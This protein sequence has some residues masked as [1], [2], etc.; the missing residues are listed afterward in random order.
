MTEGCLAASPAKTSHNSGN[1]L[2][3]G[4]LFC[5]SKPFFDGPKQ[6][7]AGIGLGKIR[8]KVHGL[9]TQ[10]HHTPI[11]GVVDGSVIH[12]QSPL[13]NLSQLGQKVLE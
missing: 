4:F 12:H 10:L 6:K 13:E 9:E 2:R 3:V 11:A 5:F 7:F 1:V 8:R